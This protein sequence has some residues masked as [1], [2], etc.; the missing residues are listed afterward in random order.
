MTWQVV[1]P[2]RFFRYASDEL[3]QEWAYTDAIKNSGGSTTTI[4]SDM[5]SRLNS[6]GWWNGPSDVAGET[7][8]VRFQQLRHDEA[9]DFRRPEINFDPR[10]G[11]ASM[12]RSEEGTSPAAGTCWNPIDKSYAGC[13][14]DLGQMSGGTSN[15]Y[16]VPKR[17]FVELKIEARNGYGWHAY[18][19]A[20]KFSIGGEATAGF[21]F[22]PQPLY[23]GAERWSY[24][25]HNCGVPIYLRTKYGSS[26]PVTVT[27]D[28]PTVPA[29]SE[30][31]AVKD[32]LIVGIGDSFASGE[33]NPDVPAKL[34][35]VNGVSPYIGVSATRANPSYPNLII[36]SREK[37]TDGRI[38]AGT[39]A[40]WLDDQ[41]HRSI[42]SAQARTAIA[43]AF[44]GAR[45]HSITFISYAC[46]G[47]EISDGL[48]WP[49]DH[50]ECTVDDSAGQRLHQPQISGVIDAL[51]GGRIQYSPFPMTLDAQDNYFRNDIHRVEILGQRQGIAVLRHDNQTCASWP[52]SSTIDRYPKLRAGKLQRPID[53]LLVSIGGNDIG[54][55]PLVSKAVM[56]SGI[57]PIDL[58]PFSDRALSIYQHAANVITI[59]EAETRMQRLAKRFNMLEAAIADRFEMRDPSHVLLTAYPRLTRGETSFCGSGNRGMNVS[60]FFSIVEHDSPETV[61]PRTADQI[62]DELNDNIRGVARHNGWTFA[63]DHVGKFAGHSFCD[64]GDE[65][66]P[67]GDAIESWDIPHK[68]R[69]DGQAN[70]QV[71]NPSTAFY[72]YE[73][74]KRWVRTFNDAYMLS[75]YFKGAAINEPAKDEDFGV[76]QA[77]RSLGGPMHP[78]AQGHAHIAD[79]ML[80]K[81]DGILFSQGQPVVGSR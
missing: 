45:H 36:P 25:S 32:L 54:F 12:L 11:W 76:W 20:C 4:V 28:D 74:R 39:A 2:F 47:A 66:G 70:W 58:G 8:L 64:F 21:G 10:L 79:A 67:V 41:C 9:I 14:S 55:G 31:I 72:P 23:R 68:K 80:K 69:S 5:E 26:Y 13:L 50:R 40:K 6:V 65:R 77:E 53:L 49:Q 42:Y 56:N 71:F 60:T 15:E 18:E 17:H 33:G 16:V 61:T 30:T 24:A 51:S 19:G 3:I 34:D 75:F 81:A 37:R 63:D 62:V 7:R 38:K 48:F 22:L 78:S 29:L 52:A 59:G 35:R 27:I 57:L 1:Q 46:S 43:L 73:S 44:E